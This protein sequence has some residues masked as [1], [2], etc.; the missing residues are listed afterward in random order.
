MPLK[1]FSGPSLRPETEPAG[2]FTMGSRACD[3]S[4]MVETRWALEEEKTATQTAA[5]TSNDLERDG[6]VRKN[7]RRSE[8][9]MWPPHKLALF[10]ESARV[11]APARARGTER[12]PT[13]RKARGC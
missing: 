4:V 11:R 6:G 3:V 12:S 10:V 1:T 2:A 9:V 13:R 7:S 8:N 5:A